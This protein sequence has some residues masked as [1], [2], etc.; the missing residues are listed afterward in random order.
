MDLGNADFFADLKNLGLE[1][2]E[3]EATRE[4]KEETQRR[5]AD[6]AI[7]SFNTASGEDTPDVTTEGGGYDEQPDEQEEHFTMSDYR[8]QA[9][10]YVDILD[11]GNTMVL[12]GLYKRKLLTAEERSRIELIKRTTDSGQYATLSYEDQQLDKKLAEIQELIDN[13]PFTPEEK[14]KLIEALAKVLSYYG[15][16]ANPTTVLVLTLIAVE[17]ARLL[18]FVFRK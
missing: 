13:I 8:I 9:E 14:K 4:Q 10:G 3:D 5:A 2:L 11:L 18:P 15:M 12:P 17:G 16:T 7:D 6:S 1:N